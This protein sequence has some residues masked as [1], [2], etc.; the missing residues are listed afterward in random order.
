MTNVISNLFQYYAILN[1]LLK[2]YQINFIKSKLI[3]NNHD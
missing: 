3:R 2:A 1:I